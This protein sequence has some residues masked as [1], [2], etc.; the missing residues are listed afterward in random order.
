LVIPFVATREE[1][2]IAGECILSIAVL[3]PR[4]AVL[5]V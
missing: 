3:V 4:R 2:R 5:G 1:S